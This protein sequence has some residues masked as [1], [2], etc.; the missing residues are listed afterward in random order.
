M[1]TL[2]DKVHTPIRLPH[3]H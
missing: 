3:H 1:R 2:E